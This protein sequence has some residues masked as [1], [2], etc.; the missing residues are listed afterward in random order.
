MNDIKKEMQDRAR[1]TPIQ[2]LHIDILHWIHHND[3][4]DQFNLRRNL[5]WFFDMAK[6]EEKEEIKDAFL[7]GTG[8]GFDDEEKINIAYKKAEDYAEERCNAYKL[9]S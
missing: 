8:I 3:Y 5:D 7:D 9:N 4:Q 6:V 2:R 1:L